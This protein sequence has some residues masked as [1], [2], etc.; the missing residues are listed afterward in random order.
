[1]LHGY[2]LRKKHL[3]EDS[4]RYFI[5]KL[6][7]KICQKTISDHRNEK[8]PDTRD[9]EHMLLNTCV[10]ILCN[11]SIRYH[12]RFP[13]ILSVNLALCLDKFWRQNSYSHV[14]SWRFVCFFCFYNTVH[15]NIY[16]CYHQIPFRV[17][18][19]LLWYPAEECFKYKKILVNVLSHTV[20]FTGLFHTPVPSSLALT[21]VDRVVWWDGWQRR[22]VP[23][24]CESFLMI[25]ITGLS[26][27]DPIAYRPL[28]YR[29][30]ITGCSVKHQANTSFLWKLY[31]WRVLS[32]KQD[33]LCHNWFSFILSYYF[34]SLVYLLRSIITFLADI[35]GRLLSGMYT[36]LY[37]P[38]QTS[39][40]MTGCRLVGD[41]L[42]S[43]TTTGFTK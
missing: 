13:Q 11:S 25:L 41:D 30:S 43:T 18:P 3:Q 31:M 38:E 15:W 9:T 5:S 26:D 10:N 7:K 33:M 2:W 34:S 39:L 20:T 21:L 8:K 29:S 32:I 28:S 16:I 22:F 6:S 40:N 42:V 36:G 19:E 23:Q 35:R 1:M 4:I 37:A 24:R 12:S 14:K 27:R 17:I